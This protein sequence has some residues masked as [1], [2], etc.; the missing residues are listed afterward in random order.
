MIFN[1]SNASG[2]TKI[3]TVPSVASS[4][5]YNG[6]EQ[7]PVW[8]AYDPEQLTMTGV[9]S[10]VN[11]GTY[12]VAFAPT[13][14]YKW[15][16]GST[17]AKFVEWTI[18]K[19]TGSLSLSAS[20]GTINGKGVTKTFTVI[21]SGDGEISVQSSNTGI[22]TV[23]VSDT[24]V[25]V[26]SV[27]YGS[28]TITVSV[29]ESTNY[30]APSDKTYAVTVDYLYLYNAGNTYNSVTGG[31]VK[32]MYESPVNE[33]TLNSDHMYV[34]SGN[35]NTTTSWITSCGFITKNKIDLTN[36]TTLY[37]KGQV[38][39]ASDKISGSKMGLSVDVE[40]SSGN[41]IAEHSNT[42]ANS[43]FNAAVNVSSLN[44][45]Y[46]IKLTAYTWTEVGTEYMLASGKF[47]QVYLA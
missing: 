18:E 26:T 36:Y 28:A 13:S 41:D 43:A 12:Q 8:L 10:A 5:T 1:V 38:I 37:V 2:K 3:E 23:S 14:K 9:T 24:T 33:A 29:A 30:T 15:A 4:L 25:T 19:A 27:G 44:N 47:T 17:E 22:A 45:S 34:K 6:S 42:T 31:W 16:D 7:S 11:A 21:G 39:N 32:T 46:Y 35:S 20:S 40:D